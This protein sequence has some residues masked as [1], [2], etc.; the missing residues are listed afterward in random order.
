MLMI[1]ITNTD[2]LKTNKC[3]FLRSIC[4]NNPKTCFKVYRDIL[5]FTDVNVLHY[6]ETVKR[7]VHLSLV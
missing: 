2:S 3:I 4:K 6:N 7:I 5:G 1:F